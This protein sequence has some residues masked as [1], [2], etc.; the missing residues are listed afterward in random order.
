L[1]R[2]PELFRAKLKAVKQRFHIPMTRALTH[3]LRD[4][5]MKLGLWSEQDEA[6]LR[7]AEA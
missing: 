1:L 5:L 6:T 7:D 2:L 3:A 4:Y